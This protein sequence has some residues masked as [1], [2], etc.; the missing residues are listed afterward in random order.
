MNIQLTRGKICSMVSQLIPANPGLS[1]LTLLS[2]IISEQTSHDSC[3]LTPGKV[4]TPS[5][6]NPTSVWYFRH[7]SAPPSGSGKFSSKV[8][9][10]KF[11]VWLSFDPPHVLSSRHLLK[12]GL[13]LVSVKAAGQRRLAHMNVAKYVPSYSVNYT[14]AFGKQ[15]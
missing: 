9:T 6:V 4:E 8:Q 10:F 15:S 12:T 14:R 13:W 7:Y 5:E 1:Y 3:Q 11:Q 2:L